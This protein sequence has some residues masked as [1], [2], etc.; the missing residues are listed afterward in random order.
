MA[1]ISFTMVNRG[2]IRQWHMGTLPNS[3]VTGLATGSE[4][5]GSAGAAGVVVVGSGVV[6]AAG[7]IPAVGAKVAPVVPGGVSA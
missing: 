4:M 2:G 6:V 1:Y 5:T 3:H 7:S